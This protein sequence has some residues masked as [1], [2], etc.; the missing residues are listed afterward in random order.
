MS[1]KLGQ[2]KSKRAS[3]DHTIACK[4]WMMDMENH[5]L[6]VPVTN[7]ANLLF[8]IIAVGLLVSRSLGRFSQQFFFTPLGEYT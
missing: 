6:C 7:L 8:N 2:S 5:R 3:V 1:V 4:L